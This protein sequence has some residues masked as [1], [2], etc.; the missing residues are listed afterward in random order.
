MFYQSKP[1]D[2]AIMKSAVKGREESPQQ[3][4]GVAFSNERSSCMFPSPSLLL[5]HWEGL[6][7]PAGG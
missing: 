4:S 6:E 3:L 5:A 1:Q 7:E 2:Q